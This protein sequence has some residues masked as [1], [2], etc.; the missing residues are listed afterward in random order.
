MLLLVFGIS[1]SLNAQVKT[2]FGVRAGWS[3]GPNGLTLRR[4]F[5]PNQAFEV[6]AG[7]NIKEGRGTE[8]PFHKQGNTFL[9]IAYQPFFMTC[10]SDIGVGFFANLGARVRYH[11]YR[12]WSLEG[13]SKITPDLFAGLGMQVELGE[14]VELFGDLNIKY[15]NKLNNAYVMGLE[16]GLGIRFVLN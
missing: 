13:A 3:G 7:Y 8:L 15:F 6:V 11:N 4:V 5:A 1:T 14:S 2:S 9:G 10:E 12:P 16:S